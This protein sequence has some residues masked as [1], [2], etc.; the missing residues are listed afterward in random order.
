MS[1]FLYST[2]P[3]TSMKLSLCLSFSIFILPPTDP[4][5]HLLYPML[6]APFLQLVF[7]IPTTSLLIIFLKYSHELQDFYVLMLFRMP[8]NLPALNKISYRTYNP[9]LSE[10]ICQRIDM[11]KASMMLFGTFGIEA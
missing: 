1:S 9:Y 6:K 10:L 4:H 7:S 3:S 11:Q 5:K 8:L 2:K